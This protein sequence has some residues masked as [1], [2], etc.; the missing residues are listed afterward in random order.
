[1]S[2]WFL[3]FH[4]QMELRLG[5]YL[6]LNL[7]PHTIKINWI[8]RTMIAKRMWAPKKM[9]FFQICFIKKGVWCLTTMRVGALESLDVLKKSRYLVWLRMASRKVFKG[10]MK[11]LCH[12][13]IVTFWAFFTM[14]IEKVTI[15]G[16]Q[17]DFMRPLK[18]GGGFFWKLFFFDEKEQFFIFY[19][20]YGLKSRVIII[21]LPL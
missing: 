19:D 21:L 6:Q 5:H 10:R 8:E 14:K 1:M 20:I 2:S 13:E 7:L 12:T 9:L 18:R 11:S 4:S 15:S 16:W 3:Y 17:S